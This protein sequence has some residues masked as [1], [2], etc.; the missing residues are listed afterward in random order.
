[1]SVKVLV[2]GSILAPI[3][4]LLRE[5]FE[6]LDL[7]ADAAAQAA[8]LQ[9]P[10]AD[11]NVIVTLSHVPLI[12]AA[13]LDRFPNVR[14]VASFGVG[15]DQVDTAAAV[16]RGILVT[17]SPGV[18]TDEVA[19]MGLA[20]TLAALRS[21]PQADR[22]V[23]DNRWETG[24]KYPL[25]LS[26]RGRKIGIVGL[27]RI[28]SAVARRFEGFN[29]EIAYHSRSPK[30]GV[31]YRYFDSVLALAGATDTL[32]LTVPGGAGTRGI[33][34]AEVLKALGPNG[35][36]VNISRGSVVDE[37]ALIAALSSGTIATAALDVF[38][39]EPHVPDALKKLD[40]IV[41][42]PH[43]GSATFATRLAMAK[44][45]VDNIRSWAGTGKVLTPV[46]ETKHL[47]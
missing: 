3:R 5:E 25:T 45:V 16:E 41:L 10:P 28:G 1:M 8:F 23:R 44:L 18:L 9:T 11:V 22:F 13:L 27:G 40:H 17:H 31:P 24:E 35:V 39:H 15:Y 29:V 43:T 7:P 26:L 2:C 36:L 47:N 38:A 33:V 46:P 21:I 20:L 30:P 37:D 4:E 34:N 19:D 32:I 6:V 14:L 42:V 12:D